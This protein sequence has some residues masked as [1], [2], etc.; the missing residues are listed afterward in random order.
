[1]YFGGTLVVVLSSYE[2]LTEALIKQAD[3]FSAR[4]LDGPI[5]VVGYTEGSCVSYL[6]GML[7]FFT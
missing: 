7:L 4:P 2:I 6:E 3:A 5:A 1:M